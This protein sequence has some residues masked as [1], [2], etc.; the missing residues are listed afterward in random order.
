MGLA[1][2]LVC[3]FV[4]LSKTPGRESLSWGAIFSVYLFFICFASTWGPIAWVYQS[5]VFPM[6]VRAKGTAAATMSN[7]FWNSVIALGTPYVSEALDY[8]MYLIFGC[9][10]ILMACF[11]VCCVPE[12]MGRSL[13]QMD[14]VFGVALASS[15][16]GTADDRQQ[17]LDTPTKL[18]GGT[19]PAV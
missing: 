17:L 5:E 19:T 3:L 6:R 13:E 11:A 1:H 15:N 2:F 8:W 4:G 10:G 7:W 16:A 18:D 14:E 9:T 12:T